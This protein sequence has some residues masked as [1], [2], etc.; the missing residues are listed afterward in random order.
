VRTSHIRH[1]LRPLALASAFAGAFA[2]GGTPATPL[3]CGRRGWRTVGKIHVFNRVFLKTEEATIDTE[4][5]ILEELVQGRLRVDL[6]GEPSGK[7][8]DLRV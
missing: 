1:R 5:V 4:A 2:A 7:L 8:D 6:F 3:L